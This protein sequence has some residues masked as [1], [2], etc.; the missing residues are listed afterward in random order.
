MDFCSANQGRDSF[1]GADEVI[2]APHRLE[3]GTEPAGRAWM[4]AD[5]EKLRVS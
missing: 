2:V 3:L 4:I 5:L 1:E